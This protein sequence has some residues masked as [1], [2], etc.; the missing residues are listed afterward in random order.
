MVVLC[1]IQWVIKLQRTTQ[2]A[3]HMYKVAMIS[4]APSTA[5]SQLHLVVESFKKT[6]RYSR[7]DKMGNTRPPR[8]NL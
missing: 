8:Y 6:I 2:K 1:E 4:E 5:F 7:F 3:N